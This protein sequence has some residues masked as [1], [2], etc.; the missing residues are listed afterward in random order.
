MSLSKTT[1]VRFDLADRYDA[2]LIHAFGR[3]LIE[4]VAGEPQLAAGVQLTE[5][6][7]NT[8]T[9]VGGCQVIGRNR[10][11]IEVRDV[12][13]ALAEAEGYAGPGVH[14]PRMTEAWAS[15]VERKHAVAAEAPAL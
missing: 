8:P 4:V 9:S 12:P 3:T 1:T 2:C 11:V 14:R 5:G 13:M 7:F 15:A 10:L 6:T